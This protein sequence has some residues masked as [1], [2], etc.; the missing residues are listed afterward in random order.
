MFSIELVEEKIKS[1]KDQKEELDNQ[2]SSLKKYQIGLLR[3]TIKDVWVVYQIPRHD[4][5]ENVDIQYFLNEEE[6][7][8]F[9]LNLTNYPGGEAYMD[10]KK[11][12]P[13][14]FGYKKYSGKMDDQTLYLLYKKGRANVSF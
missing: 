6:A 14:T 12:P 4:K 10:G 3:N 13:N 5:S 1:L 2:I 7:E 11:L 8:K 9:A